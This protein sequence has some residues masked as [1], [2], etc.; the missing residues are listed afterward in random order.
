[1]IQTQNDRIAKSI[2]KI[3]ISPQRADR[4]L[5]RGTVSSP[6]HVLAY[7]NKAKQKIPFEKIKAKY[8]TVEFEKLVKDF[9]A[10]VFKEFTRQQK[11][12][13]RFLSDQNAYSGMYKYNKKAHPELYDEDI[14]KILGDVALEKSRA[15]DIAEIDK[16]FQGWA[17][18]VKPEKMNKVIDHYAPKAAELGGNRALAD[19]GIAL[20]FNL[21]NEGMIS[22]IQEAGTKI[23]GQVSNT[24]L[25]KFR[26]TF[27]KMYKEVGMTPYELEKR[28][29]GLFP[30]T[31]KNRART[32]ARTETARVQ[33]YTQYETYG[34]NYVEKLAWSSL[35]DERTRESHVFVDGEV[36]AYGTPFM[37][38]LLYP[39]DGN[40]PA[41]ETIS[42]RCD[43]YSWEVEAPFCK[44]EGEDATD[45]TIPWTGGDDVDQDFLNKD[46]KKV[47][48]KPEGEGGIGIIELMKM[49]PKA[50]SKVFALIE[51]GQYNKAKVMIA[52]YSGRQTST[53]RK[54]SKTARARNAK[55]VNACMG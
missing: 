1:M 46:M 29:K 10:D 24:T 37:N 13:E 26:S 39:H 11:A 50:Q 8:E 9:T 7:C 34:K 40:G 15:D 42:C 30:E 20:A 51:A 55:A 45:C 47:Y 27:D 54:P 4:T 25:N 16:Y 21:K 35:I 17:D 53:I 2:G 48:A 31:Y 23:T 43:F 3:M 12:T 5:G 14:K 19:L 52:K 49:G 36:V 44:A 22:A 33:S 41:D 18:N 32:I 6:A 38:G 28:I